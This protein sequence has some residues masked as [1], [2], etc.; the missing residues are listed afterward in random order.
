MRITKKQ[1]NE[2]STAINIVLS[3]HT[4]DAVRE[5]RESI[6]YANNQFIS[7]CWSMLRISG[8]NVRPLY[9]TGLNDSHIET[10]IKRI[11][12]DFN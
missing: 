1:Y 3:N 2:I 5:Y 9:R 6:S 8:Y 11:L 4:T 12:S 7:F 10:A